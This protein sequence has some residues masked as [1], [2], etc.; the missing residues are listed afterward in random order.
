MA[1]NRVFA[2]DDRTNEFQ[3][4]PS[5]TKAGDPLLID[6]RPAVALTNR[7][8]VV[9][10]SV[11]VTDVNGTQTVVLQRGGVGLAD[12]E[13]TV[14]YTGTYLVPVTGATDGDSATNTKVYITS[15]GALTLTEGSNTLFGRV[16]RPKDWTNVAG[17][18][19]VKIGSEG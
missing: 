12:N 19:P 4:V 14:A 9:S 7:G 3:V 15:G 8:D 5:G 11:S 18:L 16:Y 1:L 2:G 6:G 10:E 17:E 13:A